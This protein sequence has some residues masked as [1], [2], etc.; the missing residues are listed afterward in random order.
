MDSPKLTPEQ[1]G[2]IV[3]VVIDLYRSFSVG[4]VTTDPEVRR[5]F[6]NDRVKLVKGHLDEMVSSG[7]LIKTGKRWYRQKELAKW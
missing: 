7:I 2:A 4:D 1:Q 3:E 5:L 6:P